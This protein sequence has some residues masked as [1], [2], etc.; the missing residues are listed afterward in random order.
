MEAALKMRTLLYVVLS[1]IMALTAT[2]AYGFLC[3][4]LRVNPRG[5]AIVFWTVLAVS[6]IFSRLRLKRMAELR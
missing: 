2:L 6:L 1:I 3:G 4:A 5:G